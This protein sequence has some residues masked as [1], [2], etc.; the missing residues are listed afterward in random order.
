[1][2]R[3]LWLALRCRRGDR[4]AFSQVYETYVDALLTVAVNL[5]GD[6]GLAEDVVQDVFVKFAQTA[7]NFRLTGSMKGY[8]VTCTANRARDIVRRR[9]RSQAAPLPD[10]DTLES[11]QPGRSTMRWIGSICGTSDWHGRLPEEQREAIVLR[12]HGG[13]KFREIAAVQGV[14]L[15]TVQ[16]R[17][18][19]GLDRLRTLLKARWFMKPHGEVE[20]LVGQLKYSARS[21]FKTATREKMLAELGTTRTSEPHSLWKLL[22]SRRAVRYAGSASILAVGLAFVISLFGLPDSV[23]PVALAD[24]L[25]KTESMSTVV[26]QEKRTFYREGEEEPTSMGHA[27]KYISA[28]LG[29]VEESYDVDGQVI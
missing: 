6:V 4:Q 11:G 28:N 20:R 23:H 26:L 21:E 12:V 22:S 14:S 13:L 25:E 5:L 9:Q 17:Y 27:V 1:M 8:L 16:S 10:A 29:Q 18:R 15:K 7:A 19:Y 24:V 3:E 2:F